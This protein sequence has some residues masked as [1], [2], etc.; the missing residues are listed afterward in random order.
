MYIII[1]LGIVAVL[2]AIAYIIDDA[3]KL[4]QNDINRNYGN[5]GKEGADRDFTNSSEEILIIDPEQKVYLWNDSYQIKTYNY[6]YNYTY[7]CSHEESLESQIFIGSDMPDRKE[8]F[9]KIARKVERLEL[10]LKHYKEDMPEAKYIDKEVT[11]KFADLIAEAKK[12]RSERLRELINEHKEKE[13]EAKKAR[14]EE[15]EK[16]AQE[17]TISTFKKLMDYDLDD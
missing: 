7:L 11:D 4:L 16:E 15:E 14:E 13:A 1:I 10:D 6:T 8:S 3:E 5:K 12:I 17:K 2:T 9:L